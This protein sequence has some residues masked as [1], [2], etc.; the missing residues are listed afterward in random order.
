MTQKKRPYNVKIDPEL[1]DALRAV[2]ERDGI[3]ESEQI[4]RGI[5]LWL[6]Q[7]GV[8][9]TERKRAAVGLRRAWMRRPRSRRTGWRSYSTGGGRTDAGSIAA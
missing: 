3:S 2:K 5:R 4:R 1:L 6:E 9:K 8:M 7:K